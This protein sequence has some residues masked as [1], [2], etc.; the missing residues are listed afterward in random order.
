M[1]DALIEHYN[2]NALE[3]LI[4]AFSFWEMRYLACLIQNSYS[5]W[6]NFKHGVVIRPDT[7]LP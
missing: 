6:Q 2:S 3:K 4:A 1:I 5:T 7:K